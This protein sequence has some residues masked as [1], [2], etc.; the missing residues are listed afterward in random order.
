MEVWAIG[1]QR[2][3]G[4]Q[5]N[6]RSVLTEDRE[7]I[8]EVILSVKVGNVRCPQFLRRRALFLDP[9]RNL[10][11]NIA[12]HPPMMEVLRA[13]YRQLALPYWAVRRSKQIPGVAV[14]RD[15]RIVREFNVSLNLHNLRRCGDRFLAGKKSRTP[16]SHS[17]KD[18]RSHVRTFPAHYVDRMI[19]QAAVQ[20]MMITG[21][22]IKTIRFCHVAVP[23]RYDRRN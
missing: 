11:E 23:T 20:S 2:F 16:Q 19:E 17:H 12:A 1:I 13:P 5:R 8:V 15:R 6:S 21:L 10:F 9:I 3:V 14:F 7:R 18:G 22:V 4:E